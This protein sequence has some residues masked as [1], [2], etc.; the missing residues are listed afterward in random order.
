MRAVGMVNAAVILTVIVISNVAVAVA[1]MMASMEMASAMAKLCDE[2]EDGKF[3]VDAAAAAVAG[4]ESGTVGAGADMPSGVH[5]GSPCVWLQQV[6][7]FEPH[8][9][10]E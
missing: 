8:L 4:T 6:S 3:G 5:A 7:V 2:I 1:V 9:E 10:G